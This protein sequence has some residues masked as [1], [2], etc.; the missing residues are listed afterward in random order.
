ME[1][2][3]SDHEEISISNT[4]T[5]PTTLANFE[6]MCFEKTNVSKIGLSSDEFAQHLIENTKNT[7]NNSKQLNYIDALVLDKLK[8]KYEGQCSNDG[9]ILKNSIKIQ[10]RSNFNF[11]VDSLRLHYTTNVVWTAQICCP[12]TETHVECRIL[13]KNKIGMLAILENEKSPIVILIPNDLAKSQEE[14]ERLKNVQEH[15]TVFVEIL[16]KKFEL[17]DTKI[18]IIARMI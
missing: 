9:F 6:S 15:D 1:E 14:K 17:H 10:K 3:K 16:G 8:K 12:R 18:M 7:K 2:Y 13:S 4:P 11:P 5:T